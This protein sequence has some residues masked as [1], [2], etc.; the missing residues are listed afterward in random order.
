MIMGLLSGAVACSGQAR[1]T[2]LELFTSEGCSS[3]PPA[4]AFLGELAQ[5]PDILALAFHVDY[6][7]SLG[8]RDRF[9]LPLSTERQSVYAKNVGSFSVY[10]PPGVSQRFQS[11]ISWLPS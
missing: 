8:W 5:R 10:T 9:A 7:D 3:C 6:W 11:R 4:E 1:P 2:V